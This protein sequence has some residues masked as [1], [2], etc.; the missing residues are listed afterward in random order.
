M[1]IKQGDQMKLYYCEAGIGGTPVWTEVAIVKDVTYD[2]SKSEID[3]TTRAAGRWKQTIS[4]MREAAIEFEIL[5]DAAVAGFLALQD[6]YNDDALIGLAVADG[7]IATSGTHYFM[8]DCEILKFARSEPLDGVV[9]VSVTAKPTYSANTPTVGVVGATTQQSSFRLTLV[10]GAGSVDLTNLAGDVDGT[11]QAVVVLRVT[12]NGANA[13]AISKGVANG[14]GLLSDDSDIVID[15]GGSVAL[16][17]GASDTVASDVKIL[18]VAGTLV[19][20][21]DW[22]IVLE[23]P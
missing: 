21:S 13:L 22:E 15:A 20:T 6:A 14:Y 16:T 3:V 11:G 17:L 23:T 4:G 19:Q 7:A 18:D 10:A 2:D 9:T 5:W 8:A 1:S 12:N